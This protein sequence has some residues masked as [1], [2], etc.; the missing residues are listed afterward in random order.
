LTNPCWATGCSSCS[1]SPADRAVRTSAIDPNDLTPVVNI[2]DAK[3]IIIALGI[4][5]DRESAGQL[6][7]DMSH[8]RALGRIGAART[9]G[10]SE[11]AN[12][13]ARAEGGRIGAG[14]AHVAL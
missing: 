3:P 1:G 4:E 10:A 13:A 12:I 9:G 8:A 14:A 7:G 5:L 6:I 11:A 2:D